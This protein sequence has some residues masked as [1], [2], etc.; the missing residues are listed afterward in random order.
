MKL[1]SMGIQ[2]FI[3]FP[4]CINEMLSVQLV[5]FLTDNVLHLI[6]LGTVKKL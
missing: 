1:R 4:D 3:N 6:S 2:D 5:Y